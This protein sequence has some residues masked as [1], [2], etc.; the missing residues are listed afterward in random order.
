VAV[1]SQSRSP[2]TRTGRVPLK[3]RLRTTREAAGLRAMVSAIASQQS[4]TRASGERTRIGRTEG[5]GR[6]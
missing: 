6:A 2:S 5:R 1:S 4:R 3:A